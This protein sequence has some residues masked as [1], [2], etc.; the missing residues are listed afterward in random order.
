MACG[1]DAANGPAGSTVGST[2][3]ATPRPAARL[4]I[5]ET[6]DTLNAI[7]ERI[8]LFAYVEQDGVR[9]L[10]DSVVWTS[11]DAAVVAVDSSGLAT[12][13][14]TGIAT[15]IAMRGALTDTVHIVSRQVIAVVR[16]ASAAETL[17]VGDTVA[18]S[19]TAYDSN[20]V[21]MV[22]PQQPTYMVAASNIS[23]VANGLF[24]GDAAG[25]GFV[26]ARVG[27]ASAVIPIL[28]DGPFTMISTGGDHA[29]ALVASGRVY[30]WGS[31]VNGQTG[32]P[33]QYFSN[34]PRAVAG[35]PSVVAIDAGPAESCAW[36]TAG[37]VYCWGTG[38]G[39]VPKRFT[40]SG[41]ALSVSAGP[42][43]MCAITTTHMV[44]CWGI[45]DSRLPQLQSISLDGG[46]QACGLD[47]PGQLVCWGGQ[48][49]TTPTIMAPPSG[50]RSLD[51]GGGVACSIAA[52]DSIRCYVGHF[53]DPAVASMPAGLPRA[54]QV[55]RGV[56]HTC[57][58]L[59][60]ASAI[61]WG[62]NYWG[63]LGDGTQ[64]SARTSPTTVGG[65][66]RFTSINAS[67]YATCALTTDGRAFCWGYA[68]F[69]ASGSAT[70]DSCGFGDVCNVRPVRVSRQLYK[71][72]R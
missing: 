65:D 45:D 23:Q 55:T 54:K 35:L 57:A 18:P 32:A 68:F 52:D 1:G 42:S 28:V 67:G 47:D 56:D 25:S 60:D 46:G 71:P 43:A 30:C 63:Q 33:D 59:F 10:A 31:A 51:A 22:L 14:Q 38:F 72:F 27:I 5:D 53:G 29:C 61:C 58:L 41:P 20:G 7:G 8:V 19:L 48:F 13:R 12:S 4:V 44:N 15:V 3:G 6:R 21:K 24:R 37:E 39:P 34:A 64:T 40:T 16:A 11:L 50:F 26:V 62:D 2:V 49:R 69:G 9:N 70:T 36:T 66:L 17:F